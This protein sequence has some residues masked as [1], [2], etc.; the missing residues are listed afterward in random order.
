MQTPRFVS[1]AMGNVDIDRLA[2]GK[3]SLAVNLKSKQGIAIVRKLSSQADVIIEPFR[4]GRDCPVTSE[5]TTVE[6]NIFRD[7]NVDVCLVTAEKGHSN[8]T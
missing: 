1:Q 8:I 2:H 5:V 7:N 3:R 6:H 4:T